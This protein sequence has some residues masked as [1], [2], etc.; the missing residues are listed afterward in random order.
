M[1]TTWDA[2][3]Q[4]VKADKLS[5]VPALAPIL[6]LLQGNVNKSI[7]QFNSIQ[8]HLDCC[9]EGKE[10]RLGEIVNNNSVFRSVAVNNRLIAMQ[11]ANTISLIPMSFKVSK[12]DKSVSRVMLIAERNILRQTIELYKKVHDIN[13]IEPIDNDVVDEDDTASSA[14]EEEDIS[15]TE[16]GSDSDEDNF[17]AMKVDQEP[18][19]KHRGKG[20]AIM[21]MKQIATKSIPD[22]IVS[23]APQITPTK[24]RKLKQIT[25]L[26]DLSGVTKDQKAIISTF[27]HEVI[28]AWVKNNCGADSTTE[29]RSVIRKRW[30][31]QA[32]GLYIALAP[33]NKSSNKSIKKKENVIQRELERFIYWICKAKKTKSQIEQLSMFVDA[34]AEVEEENNIKTKL[35]C[36]IKELIESSNGIDD[37][38]NDALVT[39]AVAE[40]D[41]RLNE[42]NKLKE[43]ET[44]KRAI[45]G[46]ARSTR[47]A[48][49]IKTM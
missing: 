24:K 41:Q 23:Q 32:P 21:H 9:K 1:T 44:R 6:T 5:F 35:G 43:E 37:K 20:L 2:I 39:H 28:L 48:K 16:S 25:H 8:A 27:F 7:D 40:I 14:S 36:D 47:N 13:S 18:A 12:K 4:L 49:L 45:D 17:G 11:E 46:P 10:E 33:S 19:T 15:G 26:Y 29:E 30:G 38:I 3:N 34:A 22:D 31:K 42:A